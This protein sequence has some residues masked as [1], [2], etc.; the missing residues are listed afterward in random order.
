MAKEDDELRKLL[1]SEIGAIRERIAKVRQ[2]QRE[3]K[4][5]EEIF[6][7]SSWRGK[8]DDE[9]DDDADRNYCQWTTSNGQVFYPASNTQAVIPPGAYEID[10]SPQAGI[11]FSKVA[12]KTSNLIRFP[13]SNSDRVI[14]EI[15][16]FW[17]NKD[18][19]EAHGMP[20]KRGIVLWGPP[21]SGKSSTIQF[22]MRDVIDRDGIVVKFTEPTLFIR[23]YRILREIQP[24]VPVVALME[25]LDSILDDYSESSVLNILDG[26]DEVE[27]I[28]F[29]ATTNYPEKL[30]ARIINRPSRFDKRYKIG[31]PSEEARRIYFEHLFRGKDI[32]GA[33]VYI[34]EWTKDTEGLSIAHLRE[35]Y[36][37]VI[38]L[39]N[40]YKEALETLKTME[41]DISST[42][43]GGFKLGFE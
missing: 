35:L 5:L 12:V 1:K 39:K 43:D 8:M 3:R 18:V 26:I 11:F 2:Q 22:I 36:V 42:H 20:Y 14:E 30:G 38:I 15:R 21:G 24:T 27:N 4:L 7:S 13:D 16:M 10:S 40:D 23:G 31:F 33:D 41:E 32:D 6:S 9:E 17:D 19:F 37:A 29:L 25:D 34:E 28:V